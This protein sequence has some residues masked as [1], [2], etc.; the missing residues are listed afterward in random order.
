MTAKRHQIETQY[1]AQDDQFKNWSEWIWHQYVRHKLKSIKKRIKR[2]NIARVAEDEDDTTS[3]RHDPE[4]SQRQA[5]IIPPSTNISREPST[6]ESTPTKQFE[7]L[8]VTT[9][10]SR[11]PAI[12][13]HRSMDLLVPYSRKRTPEDNH[14]APKR[15]RSDNTFIQLLGKMMRK[16]RVDPFDVIQTAV[17]VQ[18]E[19]GPKEVNDSP[20]IA[21]DDLDDFSAID[22]DLP[23][24][25]NSPSE[26]GS[27]MEDIMHHPDDSCSDTGV[28]DASS[29]DSSVTDD[30]DSSSTEGPGTKS[31]RPKLSRSPHRAS[32][33]KIPRNDSDSEY[34]P[35]GNELDSSDENDGDDEVATDSDEEKSEVGDESE[36]IELRDARGSSARKHTRT[37]P[38]SPSPSRS[39][40]SLTIFWPE[41]VNLDDLIQTS[42]G[43]MSHLK[44]NVDISPEGISDSDEVIILTR[45]DKRD[46]P[47]SPPALIREFPSPD[48]DLRTFTPELEVKLQAI[49]Y[50]PRTVQTD[51]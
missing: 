1:E 43:K 11:R 30:S 18:K 34:C 5:S 4:S 35:T 19:L 3:A 33:K 15:R 36:D 8:S 31:G 38:P 23:S 9:P 20:P 22:I 12:T 26:A 16:G 46:A 14:P 49:M 51:R 7:R 21:D 32:P 24:P 29:D 10:P 6:P 27:P 40:K 37:N 25:V 13:A 17:E 42:V 45:D 44:I 41:D 50:S 28:H 39:K 2:N 47:G 48:L